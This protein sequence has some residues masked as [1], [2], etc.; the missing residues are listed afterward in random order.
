MTIRILTRTIIAVGFA[1]G[2]I[3]VVDTSRDAF[4]RPLPNL[5]GER[6]TP[7]FVGN[8]FFNQNWTAAPASTAGRDGLGPLFNTRSCFTC[9]FKGGHG[10]A[11]LEDQ[12]FRT[13]ILRISRPGPHGEPFPDP[14]YGDQIQGA[15]LPGVS[16]EAEVRVAYENIPG[17]FADGEAYSLRRPLYRLENPGYGPVSKD[18]LMSARVAP[19]MIGLA[20]LERIPESVLLGMADPKDR[21]RDGISGRANLVREG[22]IGR[23]EWKAEQATVAS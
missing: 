5:Q 16:P 12:P 4:T 9:H 22:A 7:F 11:P 20:L 23:F 10:P 21:I 18:L 8:S 17:T 15:A 3:T 19:A 2:G 6:L 1:N 13:T 14:I